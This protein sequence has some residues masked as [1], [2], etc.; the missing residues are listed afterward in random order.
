MFCRR[1][2]RLSHAVATM[3]VAITCIFCIQTVVIALD[4]IE[5]ALE[6]EHD[7]NPIAGNIHYCAAPDSCD[8]SGDGHGHP[9]SHSH[10]GD[11]GTNVLV[12]S[13]QALALLALV[14][15][16]LVLVGTPAFSSLEQAAPERPPKSILDHVS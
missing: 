11:A 12:G 5:H 15:A 3:C 1:Y 10:L 4:R 9:I 6:L 13:P 7:A 8:H 2:R 16:P 14:A